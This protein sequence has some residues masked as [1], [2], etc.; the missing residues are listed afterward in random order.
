MILMN[1]YQNKI[2]YF[3]I[4][5]LVIKIKLKD[6]KETK[7]ILD[8]FEKISSID[9]ENYISNI[10][11]LEINSDDRK[12]LLLEVLD[13]NLHSDDIKAIL[14]NFKQEMLKMRE[15]KFLFK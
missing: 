1:I 4:E 7:N 12:K 10:E 2:I 8:S 14:K 6:S 3:L 11:K 15:E 13:S 9:I 5:I